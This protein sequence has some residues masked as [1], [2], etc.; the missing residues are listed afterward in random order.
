MNS[1]QGV[2]PG[3]KIYVTGKWE[4]KERLSKEALRLEQGGHGTVVST[5][6]D[7]EETGGVGSAIVDGAGRHESRARD[8]EELGKATCII[9]D[10]ID[11]DDHGDR[12][13]EWGWF[14]T[15]S[16]ERY[17]VGPE[18]NI[19]HVYAMRRYT[20]WEHLFEEWNR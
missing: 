20:D 2:V 1:K 4:A 15:R 11:E 5:W 14:L 19:F 7:Q 12:E 3:R 18:R 17:I 6:M 9:L 10:T 8:L 16:G 13:V